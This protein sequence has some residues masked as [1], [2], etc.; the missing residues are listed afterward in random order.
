[1]PVRELFLCHHLRLYRFLLRLSG[2]ESVAEELTQEV[3]L[4]A[5]RFSANGSTVREAAWLYRVAKNLW[6]D[7]WRRRARRPPEE[8]A[9]STLGVAPRQELRALLDEAL[10]QL[11]EEEREAFLLREVA[12]LSYEQIAASCRTSHAAVRSRIFRA[13]R[14]L[15]AALSDERTYTSV[16]EKV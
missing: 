13:R 2:Q 14:A 9:L 4:R 16:L 7:H 12:G 3:F 5:V 6:S 8:E 15:R 11:G 10:R 1:M